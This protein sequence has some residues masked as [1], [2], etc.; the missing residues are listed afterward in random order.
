MGVD[1]EREWTM[2]AMTQQ[3]RL[4]LVLA[5]NVVMIAGLLIVGLVSHSLGVLAAG[6]DYAAD[7]VAIL[8]GMI[9]IQIAKHPHG[10]PKATTYAAL[11]NTSVLLVVT[12]FVIVGGVRRLVTR[13]PEIHGLGVLIVSVV[14]MASM[15]VAGFILGREAAS[16]DLHMRSVLLDTVADAT[17]AAGVAATGGI[18]YVTGRL[19][20]LDSAVAVVIGLVIGFG[21]LKLLGDVLAASRTGRPVD[22][23]HGSCD[24]HV[25]ERYH[26]RDAQDDGRSEGPHDGI[27]LAPEV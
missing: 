5:L 15:I 22:C 25:S 23:E 12:V 21:T 26:D 20:W 24:D 7:S 6:G 13:T 8:L 9:S 1:G 19:Y 3:K 17:T 27:A 14:A 10:N 2:P 18:I 4:G 16:E 11:I